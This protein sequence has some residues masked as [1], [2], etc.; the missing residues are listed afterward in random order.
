[1]EL[2]GDG[3]RSIWGEE[4]GDSGTYFYQASL[5]A[6]IAIT[7][8]TDGSSWGNIEALGTTWDVNNNPVASYQD[9]SSGVLVLGIL[10]IL[11]PCLLMQS[12]EH[13]GVFR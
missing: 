2:S 9:A 10:S 13:K 3:R 11:S 12:L 6:T 1:M 4:T 8:T 5:P 7:N